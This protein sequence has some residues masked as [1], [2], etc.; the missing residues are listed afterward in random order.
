VLVQETKPTTT[1][2]PERANPIVRHAPSFAYYGPPPSTHGRRLT[3]VHRIGC[4]GAYING[5]ESVGDLPSF[6]RYGPPSSVSGHTF[7]FYGIGQTT[8]NG[9][10]GA[11]VVVGSDAHPPPRYKIANV[12]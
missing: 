4:T 3:S 2:V 9:T 12:P 8:E 1:T 10:T 11:V 5:S 6:Y 7:A